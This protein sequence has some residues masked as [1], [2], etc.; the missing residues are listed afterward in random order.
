MVVLDVLGA[1]LIVAV[2]GVGT[3]WIIN[4]ITFKGKDK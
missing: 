3:W 1:L 4:N 2:V